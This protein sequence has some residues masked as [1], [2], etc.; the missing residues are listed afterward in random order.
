MPGRTAKRPARNRSVFVLSLPETPTRSSYEHPPFC[1]NQ[2][3]LEPHGTRVTRYCA[4]RPRI[5]VVRARVVGRAYVCIAC[6][7]P[8]RVAPDLRHRSLLIPTPAFAHTSVLFCELGWR[9]C[10]VAVARQGMVT[11]GNEGE[12][13]T[14]LVAAASAST[15]SW[16]PSQRVGRRPG[17]PH[18][19]ASCLSCLQRWGRLCPWH[20][21][22]LLPSPTAHQRSEMVGK[23][24]T[25]I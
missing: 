11:Q 23:L 24:C 13:L 1:G 12:M 9:R 25:F 18:P 10:L 17:D 4:K 15:Q 14:R 16:L 7:L 19:P 3:A 22:A 6:A 5:A 20:V 21:S 8:A 2:R